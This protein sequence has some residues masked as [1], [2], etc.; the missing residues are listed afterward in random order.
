[1]LPPV[2]AFFSASTIDGAI[3]HLSFVF[4]DQGEARLVGGALSHDAYTRVGDKQTAASGARPTPRAA[5]TGPR[6]KE[7]DEQKRWLKRATNRPAVIKVAEETL[8][9]P[10]RHQHATSKAIPL[11]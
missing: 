1:M 7:P 8:A 6:L 11:I 5:D 2:G 4:A 3:H 10:G 9:T